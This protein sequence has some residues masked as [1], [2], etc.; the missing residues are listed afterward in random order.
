MRTK[1]DAVIVGGGVAG[2][3]C[4]ILLAQAGWSVALIEK[5]EFPRRKVCGE[6]IAASNLA[7]LDA[8][9]IGDEFRAIAGPPLLRVAW[10]AGESMIEAALPAF[11]DGEHPWG[12]ALGREHLDTL[13]LDRA[14]EL[15]ATILQPWMAR[16]VWQA[17]GLQHCMIIDSNHSEH[18]IV[19]PI[20]IA[21]HGSWQSGPIADAQVQ[22]PKRA[23]DLFAFK[24]NFSSAQLAQGVLP[25]LAFRGGYGGMVQGD[26]GLLTLAGCI[27]RD[28]LRR[29]RA[30]HASATAG[31]AVQALLERE[32]G[33]VRD[34]LRG[35][36]REGAW[37]SVGPIRPRIGAALRAD[38]VLA[39]GNAAGEAHPILGEG[40]SMALQSAF[41]LCERLLD[42][43]SNAGRRYARAWR[44]AF[45]ARIRLAAV[46]AHVAMHPVATRVAL[47]L[48][49]RWPKLLSIGARWGGKVRC[50]VAAE[51]RLTH[52]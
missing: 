40:I 8:L 1:F 50:V 45:A 32:V 31:D 29:W 17:D 12:C 18:E 23:A 46:Y 42:G 16:S 48:L 15:G 7:L 24:A 19:A 33:A 5:Q 34:A 2:S 52:R 25:V 22:R 36:Q 21:A 6:C 11:A 20:L 35:A 13:L 37:L 39:V 41:L 4:A 51:N 30:E 44:R 28:R 47:P 26:H 9:G 14:R 49:R 27:R 3:S 10:C 43:N 38:G